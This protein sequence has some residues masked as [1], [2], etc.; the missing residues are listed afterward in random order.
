MENDAEICTWIVTAGLFDAADF[1]RRFCVYGKIGAAMAYD[2]KWTVI[3]HWVRKAIAAFQ[4]E[5]H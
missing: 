4:Q 3:R 5:V 1:D 2:Y